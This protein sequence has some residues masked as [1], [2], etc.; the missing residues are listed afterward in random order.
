MFCNHCGGQLQTGQGFCSGCGKAVAAPIAVQAGVGGR[1]AKHLSALALF[2]ICISGFRVL[3]AGGIM[4]AG[5]MVR[6]LSFGD[7]FPNHLIRGLFPAI[8]TLML[9]GAIA[10]CICAGGLFKKRPW[11][12]VLG[13]ILGTLALL[14]PPFGTALGIYTLWVLLPA[15]SEREY[16]ALARP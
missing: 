11:A 9:L 1:V 13:L 4:F 10:G 8:G 16:Q 7:P 12:R 2:W 6:N 5:G 3:G 14:D 15:E